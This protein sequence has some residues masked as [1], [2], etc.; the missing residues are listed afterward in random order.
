[1]VITAVFT[2][3]QG[4]PTAQAAIA[5]PAGQNQQDAEVRDGTLLDRQGG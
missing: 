3:T 4:L 5:K 1:V 2:E